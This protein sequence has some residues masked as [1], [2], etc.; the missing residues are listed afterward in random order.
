M[1]RVAKLRSFID[2]NP[3]MAM[4]GVSGNPLAAID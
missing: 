3:H 1:P 4:A 2:T